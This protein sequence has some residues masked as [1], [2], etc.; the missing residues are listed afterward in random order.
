VGLV[1]LHAT[2]VDQP[3]PLTP[4]RLL[5]EWTFE[6][7]V[8]LVLAAVAGLYIAGV[9]ALRRRGDAWPMRRSAA[10]L[11]GGVGSALVATCSALGAY[12]TVLLSVH[13][14]QHM[15]LMMMT[16]MF[17]ALGAPV[18]LALRTLPPRPRRLLLAV[19][20]S[21]GA[22]ALTFPPVALALFIA[23]PFALYYSSFYEF[24]LRSSFWHAFVH[25]HF[26]LI[27]ALLMWPLIGL[28]PVPG[29]VS[30]PLRMLMLFVLLPFHAFLGVSIM[31]SSVLI[32]E[33]WYLSFD[34][35]WSPSPLQD[36]YIAGGIMWGSGDLI[37]VVLMVVIFVQWFVSS[38]REAAREDRRLDLLEARARR[39]SYDQGGSGEPAATSGADDPSGYDRAA[40]GWAGPAPRAPDAR[41]EQP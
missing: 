26:V 17:L 34:R 5:T 16:P 2:P 25:V 7:S 37:A 4:A 20:H 24:S 15:I 12:D 40:G 23:T 28:D 3:P 19:L 14:V 21:R 10:F 39:Q 1:P 6:W 18:T 36:Q 27:G 11:L 13:M 9:L 41:R 22:R 35:S 30:Y 29:R 8:V 38:Q 32:A 31:S 33:K